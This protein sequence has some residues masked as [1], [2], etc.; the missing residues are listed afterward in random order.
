MITFLPTFWS[1]PDRT[2]V[3]LDGVTYDQ[4]ERLPRNVREGDVVRLFDGNN[5]EGPMEALCRVRSVDSYP[6]QRMSRG[7]VSMAQVQIYMDNVPW[8][9][10]GDHLTIYGSGTHEPFTFYRARKTS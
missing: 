8:W 10:S 5:P 4:I 1:P 6:R 9:W 7:R 2:T 3:T